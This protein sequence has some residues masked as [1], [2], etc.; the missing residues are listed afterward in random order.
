MN[1]HESK[2]GQEEQNWHHEVDQE[3]LSE[4]ESAACHIMDKPEYQEHGG[5]CVECSGDQSHYEALDFGKSV[6]QVKCRYEDEC[7][8]HGEKEVTDDV[9]VEG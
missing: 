7:T 3:E 2:L 8:P 9:C 1:R 4:S 5:R 6:G